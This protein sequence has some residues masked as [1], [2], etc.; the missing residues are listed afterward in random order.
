MAMKLAKIMHQ[1]LFTVIYAGFIRKLKTN[2]YTGNLCHP[3]S[4]NGKGDRCQFGKHT[5]IIR[6]FTP[7]KIFVMVNFQHGD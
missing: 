2:L 1:L 4:T 7:R 3:V 6:G 5:R